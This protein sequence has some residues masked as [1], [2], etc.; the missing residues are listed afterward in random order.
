MRRTAAQQ[1]PDRDW[2]NDGTEDPADPNGGDYPP[3][4]EE[5]RKLL[6]QLQGELQ[7]PRLATYLSFITLVSSS[8][9]KRSEFRLN[10]LLT[11]QMESDQLQQASDTL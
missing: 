10:L 2:K 3:S 5:W 8:L 7:Q 4:W 11:V 1:E 9:V 6:S